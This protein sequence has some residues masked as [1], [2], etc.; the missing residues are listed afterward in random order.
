MI[1]QLLK[2]S[3]SL[4]PWQWRTRIKHIPIISSLQR[5][6]IKHFLD[7]Q[8]FI[9]KINAGPACGLN[10]PVCLPEDKLI[11]TGTYEVE[12][13][14]ALANA[15]QDG[16]V[17]YD[18]GG[19]RGFFSGVLAL[20]GAKKVYIFEPFPANCRQIQAVIGAN[21]QLSSMHLLDIAVGE[22]KGE[23]EFLVMP[24]ASMG[25]LSSSSFQVGL[26]EQEKITVQVE[27]L[28]ELVQSG[29]VE[30]PNLIKI[31]VE[32]A[33]IFVLRGAIDT[34]QQYKPKLFIEI[35][36]R[37]LARE[38]NQLLTGIGYN[39]VVMETD[40]QPDFVSEPEVCHFVAQ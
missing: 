2:Q 33:E 35:H 37:E 1:S 10:Y 15:V 8:K 4:I 24:E 38:C 23:A 27:K 28:D 11:W 19:F 31:D 39:V 26:Q 9:Y 5:W 3:V 20:A 30:R 32:G 6:L 7:Q 16:D 14:Q 22:S 18:I 17:C 34:L 25:K 40:K 12:F 21:P 36:S 13:A 29:S